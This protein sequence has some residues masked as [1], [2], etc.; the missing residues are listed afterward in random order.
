VLT[1]GWLC[2]RLI[3]TGGVP[4]G[5]DV[6]D[7]V[8]RAQQNAH[9]SVLLSPWSPSGLGLARQVSLDNFLGLLVLVT[10]DAPRTIAMLLCAAL[11]ASG[12]SAYWVAEN[13]Y[14]DRVTA[15]IAGLVYMT[16]QASLGR[17]ASGW[18]HYEILVALAPILVHLWVEVVNRYEPVRAL[19]FALGASAIAFARQDIIFWLVPAFVVYAALHLAWTSDRR[20]A[21]TNLG[22]AT[23]TVIPTMGA[24]SLYFIV[25]LR[26]GIRAPWVTTGQVFEAIRFNLVDRSLDAYQSLLGFGRDLGYIPFNGEAWWNFHPWFPQAIY[27]ALQAVVVSACFAVLWHRRDE[28]TVYLV[29]LAIVAAFLGKGIRGPVGEPYW[30][31]VQHLPV[32]G[33]LRGPNRWLIEQSFCYAMLFGL[34]VRAAQ[35]ALVG[36]GGGRLAG[37]LVLTS[38]AVL[39]LL[40]VAPTLLAGLRTWTPTSGQLQ[41]MHAVAAEPGTFSVASVPYDQSMRYL[42]S[43]SYSGWEHDLGVE[44]ALYTGHSAIST[45]S[46][47]QRGSD[48]VDY[49]ASL[50]EQGDPA[51]ARLLGGVGVRYLLGFDY[52]SGATATSV[53]PLAA[54]QQQRALAK[55]PD[56]HRLVSSPGG[57]VYANQSASSFLSFRTNLC[58]VLGGRNGVAAFADLPGIKLQD[59]AV[60]TAD[61][62]LGGPDGSIKGL[63]TTIDRADKIVVADS[64]ARDLSVLS[65]PPVSRVPG[66]TS[67]PG[68]DRRVGLLLN[69]ESARRGS[70]ADPSVPPPALV[71]SAQTTFRLSEPRRL[72]LWSRVLENRTAG[73]ITF[74]ID[75]RMTRQ[76]LPLEAGLGRFAWLRMGTFDFAAGHHTVTV[77]GAP[78]TFGGSFEIDESRLVDPDVRARNERRIEDALRTNAGRVSYV[79]SLSG[80]PYERGPMDEAPGKWITQAAAG[81]AT[82]TARVPHGARSFRLTGPR[83][84]YTFATRVFPK[85]QSWVRR[86]FAVVGYWSSGDGADYRLL[87]DFD[88]RHTQFASYSLDDATPGWHTAAIR[89]NQSWSHVVDIRVSTRSKTDKSHIVLG[90]VHLLF[91]PRLTKAVTF[92]TYPIGQTIVQN[93]GRP[94]RVTTTVS[95]RGGAA[96]V[97]ISFPRGLASSPARVWFG[98]RTT[99]PAPAAIPVTFHGRDNAHFS[100][101]FRSKRRGMLVFAQTYDTRWRLSEPGVSAPPVTP[102]MSLVSGFVLGRGV[103]TGSIEFRGANLVPIGVALSLAALVLTV[104]GICTLLVIRQRRPNPPPRFAGASIPPVRPR[105]VERTAQIATL[106]VL[107]ACV[108]SYLC[109]AFALVAVMRR[110]ASWSDCVLFSILLLGMSPILITLGKDTAA[111][112]LAVGVVI[113]MVVAVIRIVHV[114][115]KAR[116]A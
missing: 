50:L 81:I 57:V 55:Q 56:A 103:H 71:T 87:F 67:D 23:F 43:S 11:L 44:S 53:G 99:A 115:R 97:T 14:G 29:V 9:W 60:Q 45:N 34:A 17:V 92:P 5:T 21:I 111:D 113:A 28:R 62:L 22:K 78:S 116:T 98:V 20:T 46:W 75:G 39:A 36:R 106:A 15:T 12:F 102:A 77:S 108:S 73:Q 27:Y 109:I 80:G 89:I 110:R 31:G 13:W 16:A 3:F 82:T 40:P 74:T 94:S 48:F 4:A 51:F 61:D 96:H 41:L 85:P 37:R 72:E 10:G 86:T 65:A 93:G 66:I 7:L 38:G 107:A 1:A 49:T 19:L 18:L 59:W 58:V 114:S 2:R 84:F 6:F 105:G 52:P 33:S 91:S 64:T 104:V 83:T 63:I 25:P 42:R 32:F 26:A 47:D 90:S 88:A 79:L 24:L 30:F 35:R 69:D 68:L 8:T 54:R 95:R 100:Y 101:S 112:A 70:L 76:L